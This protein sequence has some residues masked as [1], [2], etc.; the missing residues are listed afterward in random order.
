MK[1]DTAGQF[2]VTVGGRQPE[3]NGT[4]KEASVLKTLVKVL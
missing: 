4:A 3:L 1:G 2:T